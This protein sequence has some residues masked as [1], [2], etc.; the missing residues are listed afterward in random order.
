MKT[1]LSIVLMCLATAAS[2]CG[3]SATDRATSTSANEAS[4]RTAVPDLEVPRGAIV[5]VRLEQALSTVRNRT[6]DIFEATLDEPVT[7]GG[8]EV[9]PQG[10][11][12]TGHVTR[13]QASGHLEGRAVLA[14]TLDEFETQGRHYP[15]STSPTQRMSEGHKK[16]N[17]E[18]I[19]GGTGIGAAVGGLAGGG[20]GA[21]IGAAIG[22]G[23]G[24]GVA[25]AT[26]KKDIELPAET[27]LRFTLKNP[28]RI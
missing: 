21:A 25:A 1:T 15:I 6:G 5:A 27:L 3:P 4:A 22:A 11:K 23:G 28:V 7:V 18:I 12:F 2:A 10:T 16:R 13:S 9:L 8:Q 26:G 19:G 20:K 14:M 24:T 17:L